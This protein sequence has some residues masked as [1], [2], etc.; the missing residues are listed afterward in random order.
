MNYDNNGQEGQKLGG[1]V[2][3]GGNGKE[4]GQE[5]SEGEGEDGRQLVLGHYLILT[6]E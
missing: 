3:E 1:K 4:E 2:G 6:L 5:R